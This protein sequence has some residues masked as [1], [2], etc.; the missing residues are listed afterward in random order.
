MTSV[1]NMAWKVVVGTC[2]HDQKDVHKTCDDSSG[3][4]LDSMP[5]SRH[6]SPHKTIVAVR[7]NQ[8]TL[9]IYRGLEHNQGVCDPVGENGVLWT[10][11]RPHRDSSD[12]SEKTGKSRKLI[13][14]TLGQITAARHLE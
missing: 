13:G 12:D 4:H 1:W 7:L 11:R 2:L 10:A 5:L 14:E 8:S 3:S 9:N 6:G